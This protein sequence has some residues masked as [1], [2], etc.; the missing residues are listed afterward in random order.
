MAET[1]WTF[2]SN[3]LADSNVSRGVSAGYTPPNGGGSY[4]FACHS[5]SAVNGVVGKRC[6]ESGFNPIASGKGASVRGAIRRGGGDTEIAPFLF[7]ALDTADAA[8]GVAYMLGLAH[9]EEPG[10]L[11]LRKG[12]L[13]SGLPESDAGVLRKSSGTYARDTWL[14]LR[15]DVIVQPS[16]DVV[17]QLF[18]NDLGTN[19]VTAPT[20][21]D[22]AGMADY[23]DDKN[24]INSGSLPY[25]SGG[26]V[27]IGYWT[28]DTGRHAWFDHVQIGRQL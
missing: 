3:G 4:V 27:G 23:T 15:L 18:A 10:H 2:L 11:V 17:I 5:L 21:D 19:A 20:W 8:A 25:S 26:Y 13:A 24:G 14:H 12:D 16:G 28:N 6:N 1:N 7:A 22:I 9:D